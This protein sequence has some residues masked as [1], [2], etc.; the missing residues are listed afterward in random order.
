MRSFIGNGSLLDFTF[1]FKSQKLKQQHEKL[2]S[3]FIYGNYNH[4]L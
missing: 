2:R 1:I 3:N 4:G